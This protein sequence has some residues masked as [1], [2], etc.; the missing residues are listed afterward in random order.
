M[1]HVGRRARRAP[2]HRCEKQRS[3]RDRGVSFTGRPELL[4]AFGGASGDPTQFGAVGNPGNK[5]NWVNTGT[6]NA[7]NSQVYGLET[8]YIKA[9]SLFR[10]SISGPSSR[11]LRLAARLPGDLTFSGGYIQA[12]YFL[13]GENRQYDKRLGRL[14]SNYVSGGPHTPFWLVRDE[15]GRFN[16]GL[17]AWE[18]A[19]KWSRLDLNNGVVKGGILDN[20]SLGVNWHLNNNLRV[21]FMYLHTDRYETKA[22]VSRAT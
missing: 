19:A 3:D 22:G 18:L 20:L 10:A 1:S 13:T 5:V 15:D 8:L 2:S 6:I 12:S 16:H 21:Q 17:G 14:A 9:R 7:S 4:D 11:T